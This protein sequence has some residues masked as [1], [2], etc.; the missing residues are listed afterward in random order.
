MRVRAASAKLTA[1]INAF[2]FIKMIEQY[3]IIGVKI[4]GKLQ[5]AL[6]HCSPANQIYFQEQNSEYL[7]IYTLEGEQVLGK[8]LK[9]GI[10]L[11]TFADYVKNIKSILNKISPQH[12][13]SESEIKIYSHTLIG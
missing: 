5:E 9:S 8:R 12:S 6:D 7:H 4:N 1:G 10:N 11:E 13:L 3:L 2:N